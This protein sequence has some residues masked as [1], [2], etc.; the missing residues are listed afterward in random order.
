[1]LAASPT[2]IIYKNHEPGDETKPIGNGDPPWVGHDNT[3]F[4][5]ITNQGEVETPED[6]LVT[7]YVNTPPGVGDDGNWA[8]FD[9]VNVGKLMPDETKVIEAERKWRPA[10]GEH[11]CVKVQIHS[12][13][14][15]IT[16]DNNQAQENFSEFETGAAS[17]YAPVE[18]DFLARN[19]Y[20]APG[21]MDLQARGL[22]EQWFAA[23]DHGSV[24]LPPLGNKLVHVVI[25]TDRVGEWVA[26]HQDKVPRKVPVHIEGWML[27]FGEHLEFP[28]GG[29]TALV[30][31]VRKVQIFIDVAV[32][33]GEIMVVRGHV[34]PSTGV[35]PV[36]IHYN[37][38]TGKLIVERLQTDLAGMFTHQSKFNP[39]Q[40]P[41]PWKVQ[42]LLLEG[43]LAQSAESAV[44]IVNVPP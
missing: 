15:E 41:G 8:P 4:A 34:A 28:V 35:A 32:L 14:G 10:V 5:R 20:D 26:G 24:F 30:S 37:S 3:L 27:H 25:W 36:A 1:M 6:V 39:G 12:Q 18:F 42:A 31:A 19:P 2:V 44:V 33:T 17:P 23:F 40:E 7:F 38:P 29:I 43:S 11:T 13:N 16:F 21:I 22:P 9:T